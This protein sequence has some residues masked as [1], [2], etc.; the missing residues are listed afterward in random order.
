MRK[1]IKKEHL[2]L[3]VIARNVFKKYTPSI[4]LLGVILLCNAL[5]GIADPIVMRN[6]TDEALFAANITLALYLLA[7]FMLNVSGLF[8]ISLSSITTTRIGYAMNYAIKIKVFN[9]AI[10]QW[11]IDYTVGDLINRVHGDSDTVGRYLVNYVPSF[12]SNCLHLLINIS[13]LFWFDYLF[14][15][16][17]LVSFPILLHITARYAKV[18]R[19]INEQ[20]REKSGMI[21]NFVQYVMNTLSMVIGSRC[22][23]IVTHSYEATMQEYNDLRLT[24]ARL[25]IRSGFVVSFAHICIRT[26]FFVVGILFVSRQHMTFGSFLAVFSLS[27]RVMSQIGFFADIPMRWAS[28]AV[29]LGRIVEVCNKPAYAIAT[30]LGAGG[31]SVVVEELAVASGTPVSFRTEPGVHLGIRGKTGAGKTTLAMKIAGLIPADDRVTWYGLCADD[32]MYLPATRGICPV[33]TL[34][35]NLGGVSADAEVERILKLVGMEERWHSSGLGFDTPLSDVVMQM[36]SG[37]H[38]RL[39]FGRVFAR[40]PV[41]LI[42]DEAVSSI[43]QESAMGILQEI[44]AFL[45]SESTIVI[46]SH[47]E[48]DFAVCQRVIEINEHLPD[49]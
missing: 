36:S 42:L 48:S 6:V 24:G 14:G 22:Q 45:G 18:M 38:Q 16:I 31:A 25:S 9:E 17:A 23:P 47:R 27:N 15:T 43:D 12:I 7:Y 19:E 41:L 29:A 11:S 26:L 35:D 13:M 4:V 46:I 2:F 3:L 5:L 10:K 49:S 32:I 44:V 37:E 21:M 8:L 39:A 34:K 20:T 33:L 1:L 28:V 40:K 30:K